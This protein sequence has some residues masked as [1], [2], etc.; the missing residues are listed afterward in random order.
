LFCILSEAILKGPQLAIKI[1]RSSSYAGNLTAASILNQN[2]IPEHL[3]DPSIFIISCV[4]FEIASN[5]LEVSLWEL[6]EV[7][8][9]AADLCQSAANLLSLFIMP[10]AAELEVNLFP[11]AAC[12]P[13]ARDAAPSLR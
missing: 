9:A 6:A 7:A 12:P 1:D 5:N 4:S 3:D 2:P 10:M 13:D 8:E 11:M